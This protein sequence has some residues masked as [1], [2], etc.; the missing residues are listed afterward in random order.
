LDENRGHDA[1][2]IKKVKMYLLDH[3]TSGLEMPIMT[4]VDATKFTCARLKAGLDTISV[5]GNVLRDYN[6]DLFPIIELGTVRVFRR[7]STL[8]DAIGSH[9]CLFEALAYV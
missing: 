1:E 5:T 9:A 8:E 2:M 4:P 7:K 3:D 6:T